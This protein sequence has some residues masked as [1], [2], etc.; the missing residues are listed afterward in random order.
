MAVN[1]V[2]YGGETLVDLTSDT[3]TSETLAAGATAHNSAGETVIGTVTML[4]V[5]EIAELAALKVNKE[6]LG[7]EN[8]DNTSD[9]DK[10]VSTAQQAALADKAPAGF[11]VDGHDTVIAQGTSGIWTYRKW[12]SGIAEC[13]LGN[14]NFDN[15]GVAAG[16]SNRTSLAFPFTFADTNLMQNIVIQ[17]PEYTQ[18][19]SAI[20][21]GKYPHYCEMCVHN[22]GSADASG[23]TLDI[24]ITGRWK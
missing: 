10:P 17:A 3:V 14:F 12:A 9:Q 23:F 11:A 6:S 16:G 1:K 2:V 19:L 20:F 21:V 18:N 7:L 5:D 13:W 8:V 15:L 24:S 4:S 22:H